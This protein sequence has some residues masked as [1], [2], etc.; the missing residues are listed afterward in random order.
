MTSKQTVFFLRIT[1]ILIFSPVAEFL[2]DL[3]EKFWQELTTLV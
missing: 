2:V 1:H 3:A